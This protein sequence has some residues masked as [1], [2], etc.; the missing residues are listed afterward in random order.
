[1]LSAAILGHVECLKELISEGA[2]INKQDNYYETALMKIVK[3]GHFD[4][5]E[6]MLK[7][8]IDTNFTDN[9]GNASMIAALNTKNND[10]KTA[11][12]LAVK[13]GCAE[14]QGEQ[15][16]VTSELSI[17]TKI[18][19]ALLRAGAQFDETYAEFCSNANK[20]ILEMLIAAGAELK[21]TGL[22]ECDDSLKVL[23]RK[24]IRK[25]LNQFHPEANLYTT[26][27]KL[28]LPCQLEAYLLFYTQ[29]RFE[30]D[31]KEREKQLLKWTTKGDVKGVLSLIKVGVDVN[32]QDQK[33]WTALM[34]ASH[35]GHVKVTELLIREGANVNVQSNVGDTALILATKQN[36]TDCVQKLLEFGANV[37][38]QGENG[39]TALMHASDVKN[40]TG[41][42]ATALIDG[43]AKLD[44]Q[45][46][47]GRTALSM[48]ILERNFITVDKLIKA[49]ADVNLADFGGHTALHVLVYTG[50][51]ESIKKC[52]KAGADLNN[53]KLLEKFSPLCLAA[54]ARHVDCI[55]ELI[56][57]GADPNILDEDGHTPLMISASMLNDCVTA[58]LRAGAEVSITW[59][60]F[61][62][63][64]ASIKRLQEPEGTV[65]N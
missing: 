15:S 10:G 46:I 39:R 5:I 7:A 64:R 18:V 63:L 14:L 1:M 16:E 33:G 6:E 20:D 65:H 36:K 23:A 55:K 24:S 30:F 31:L 12:Y 32:I 61:N 50:D 57:A 47:G 44:I 13:L 54:K 40:E 48:A 3:A 8:G 37:N 42:C 22:F 34:I 29:H 41:K 9:Y 11:L 49:G 60:I 25:H 38:I 27:P 19:Y 17:N 45:D 62:A 26:I 4:C 52:I 59:L 51:V 43:G 56:R 21:E 2:D 58:L 28:G 53:V 35:N